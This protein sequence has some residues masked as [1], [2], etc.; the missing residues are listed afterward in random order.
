MG[1]NYNR[2]REWYPPS[3]PRKAKHGIKAHGSF[4]ETWWASRWIKVLESYSYEWSN[5]LQRGRSY[6]KR[7][8]VLDY[9][10]I[11]GAIKA[12]VQGSRPKPYRITIEIKA[13]SDSDWENVV[14]HLSSK[15]IFSAR[16]LSGEMPENIEET[17]KAAGASLFP[18][19]P[20]DIKAA[21]SC[22]DVANPCKHIAAVFYILAEEFDRNPFM[23]FQVRGRDRGSLLSELRNRR[24]GKVSEI[25]AVE[26]KPKEYDFNPSKFWK[27][28]GDK[29]RSL[30]VP[31][32][33]SPIELSVLKRLGPPLFW[34]AKKDFIKEMAMIYKLVS[35]RAMKVAYEDGKQNKDIVQKG[36]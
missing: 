15:A 8:Q 11:K 31:I 17:F 20:K 23:M 7:G 30:T 4:V 14:R 28:G 29:I 32:E 19:S 34:R 35:E 6:A 9:A 22:P 10:A 13:L 1:W 3:K 16:L 2:Y 26:S 21:C 5:R 27:M 12:K 36:E 24:T 25:A 18:K 33:K